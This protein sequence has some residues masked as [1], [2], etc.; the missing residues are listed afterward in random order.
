VASTDKSLNG[1]YSK[2]TSFLLAEDL[3]MLAFVLVV[4][5]KKNLF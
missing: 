5:K 2:T 4:R 3:E 1:N